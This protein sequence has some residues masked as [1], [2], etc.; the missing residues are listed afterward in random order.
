MFPSQGPDNSVGCGRWR[1]LSTSPR[2]PLPR[3]AEFQ[4]DPC[5][6]HVSETDQIARAAAGDRQAQA[7][8]VN[9]HMPAVYALARRMVRSD[10]EAEDVTQEA[11]LRAW[12][13][14]PGWEPRAKFSTWLYRVTLNLCHDRLRKHR[15]TVM[16]EPPD[17]ED[18]ALKP[19][20]ALDQAQRLER[21]H[22]ALDGLPERQRAAIHLCALDGRTNIEAAEIMGISIEA[23]ESL[24]ARARRKLRQMISQG[25]SE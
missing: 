6:S 13:A 18:W 19:D 9:R 20:E 24:L 25:A 15:E 12:K 5:V 21:L 14:L 4:Q 10:A 1:V 3:P 11:F 2:L 16:A 22:S 8:L 17:R 7:A 23:V